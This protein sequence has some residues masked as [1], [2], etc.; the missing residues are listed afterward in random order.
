MKQKGI[1]ILLQC[2]EKLVL[3][4][5][6]P[7]ID[8]TVP[9]KCNPKKLYPVCRNASRALHSNMQTLVSASLLRLFLSTHFPIASGKNLVCTS[10]LRVSLSIQ[11]PTVAYKSIKLPPCP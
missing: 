1:Q 5:Y 2:R 8:L 10:L 11:F 4:Q 3:D 7:G 6:L 9:K